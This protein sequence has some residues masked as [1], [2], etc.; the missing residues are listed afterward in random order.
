M[1]TTQRYLTAK[2]ADIH[3]KGLMPD[4]PVD[5]P[6]VEFGTEPPAGDTMLDRALQELSKQQRPAA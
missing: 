1:I 2:S 5:E 6:D 4:V 3:E